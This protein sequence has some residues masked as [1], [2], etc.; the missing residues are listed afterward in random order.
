MR[1]RIAELRAMTPPSD[2]EAHEVLDACDAEIDLFDAHGDTYGY[3][4]FVAR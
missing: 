4:F 3:E 1:I 2:A